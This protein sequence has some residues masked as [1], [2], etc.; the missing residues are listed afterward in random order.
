MDQ[1]L[2][3]ARLALE[4]QAPMD[5]TLK[6]FLPLVTT[7]GQLQ[8]LLPKRPEFY[9]AAIIRLASHG[10]ARLALNLVHE[11]TAHW[12]GDTTVL[13]AEIEALIFAAEWQRAAT[14][15]Q[16]LRSRTDVPATYILWA[17]AASHEWSTSGGIPVLE[18]ARRRFAGDVSV[19]F[20]LAEACLKSGDYRR[21]ASVAEELSGTVA[22]LTARIR[23]HELLA[24]IHQAAG[25]PNRAAFESARA[26]NLRETLTH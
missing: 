5:N 24:R 1:A 6:G 19:N 14:A 20:S 26:R 17:R 25:N 13:S 15:A 18:E 23:A 3:E 22:T 11:A 12:P 21:A 10:R 8:R 9:A 16:A 4:S 2:L 7:V